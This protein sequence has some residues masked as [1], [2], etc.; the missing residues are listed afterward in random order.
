MPAL[1]TFSANPTRLAQPKLTNRLLQTSPDSV[2]CRRNGPMLPISSNAAPN[3][4]TI[5]GLQSVLRTG[6]FE[7]LPTESSHI[8]HKHWPAIRD[9]NRPESP[10]LADFGC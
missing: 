7:L 6:Q 4:R 3:F 8:A 10:R 1:M 9:G 2:S 5:R